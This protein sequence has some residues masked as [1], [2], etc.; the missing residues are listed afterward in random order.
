MAEAVKRGYSSTLRAAQARETRRSI[1]SAAAR[2]FVE[3]GFGTTTID[4]I[5]EA[6]GV[7]RK[8]VFTAVGGKVELL[9]LAID[10]AVAGDDEPV[11]LAERPEIK[12]LF[13]ERDPA[14]LLRGW[15]HVQ[16]VID[17]RVAG[18]YQALTVA[19]GTDPAARAIWEE[20]LRQR[21]E[22]A[23]VTV[24]RLAAL[25][26]LRAGLTV[27]EAADIAW[28]HSDPVLYE[29][30]VLRRHWSTDRFE[31]WLSQAMIHQL[32]GG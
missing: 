13:R 27:E 18:L 9:K 16:V 22:G 24:D 30:L 29:R 4:G 6:A 32:L 7:S 20:A 15:L 19:A 10:W 25:G 31:E 12:R 8:T 1:V 2:L 17:S 14:A 5:A 21:H 11:P 28:L 26:G 3:D 23:S